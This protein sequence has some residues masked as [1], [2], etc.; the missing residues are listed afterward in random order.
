MSLVTIG[1]L[2]W[3]EVIIVRRAAVVQY[4]TTSEGAQRNRELIEDVLIEMAARDPGG[5]QYQVLLLDDGVGFIHVVAFD[6][7]ADPFA[8]CAAY[9]E[10]HRE[11][12]QRLATKPVVT[13]AVLI[14]SY[15][16]RR[17]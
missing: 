15:P 3:S 12:A 10:F 1:P 9:R 14:G 6:G 7:T 8:D 13:R 16:G 17:L 11:L 5:V 4:V 2:Y